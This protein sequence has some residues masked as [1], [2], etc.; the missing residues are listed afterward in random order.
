MEKIKPYGVYYRMWDLYQT[1]KDEGYKKAEEVYENFTKEV[2]M[3]D[4]AILFSLPTE[5]EDGY[6]PWEEYFA[7]WLIAHTDLKS[8]DS[9][10]IFSE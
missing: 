8:G 3:D 7:E 6:E 2:R 9:V 4:C 10:L 1:M 5:K